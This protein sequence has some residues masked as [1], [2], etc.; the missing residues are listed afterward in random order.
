M[1]SLEQ[2]TYNVSGMSCEHC[3]AA[4]SS[5]LGELP[6]VAAVEVDLSSGAVIVHASKID[7]D[8]VRDA[9]EEA[10]YSLVAPA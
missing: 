1:G 2:H 7:D 6:G 3:V 10:G 8:A 5:E 4:V 9:V